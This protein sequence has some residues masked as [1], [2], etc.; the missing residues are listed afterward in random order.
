MKKE[1]NQSVGLLALMALLSTVG[2]VQASTVGYWRFESGDVTGDSSGN[3]NTLTVSPGTVMVAPNSYAL[4]GSGAGSAFP[5]TIP[6]TGTANGSAIQGVAA[7]QEFTLAGSPNMASGYRSTIAPTVA[8]GT[9]FGVEA[10]V[11]L[12]ATVTTTGSSRIIAT[13]GANQTNGSWAFFVSSEWSGRGSRNLLFQ[14]ETSSGTAWGG[15]TFTTLDSNLQLEVG[16]DYYVGFTMDY[17]T[18]G[19]TGA[20]FFL[21]DLTLGTA[22]QTIGV[23]RTAS[24]LTLNDST[25]NMN[26]GS[27]Q[28]NPAT[29]GVTADSWAG[30][31]DE[32]RLSNAKLGINDLL[33]SVPE[34]GSAALAV[35]GLMG[36][37]AMARR[38]K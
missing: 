36:A 14:Y 23:S 32:L 22:M 13:Q 34:P 26:I 5:K 11:N 6:Q 25:L 37:L 28:F 19:T 24:N 12:S 30:T 20:I 18:T 29:V 7:N 31:I 1:F 27:S 16:H 4:P 2:A 10:L 38:R 15:G 9:G 17:S 33:I 8:T 35:F 3:N 21:Q